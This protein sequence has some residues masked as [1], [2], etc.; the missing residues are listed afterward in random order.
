MSK[1]LRF[2]NRPTDIDCF[3]R[4]NP[5]DTRVVYKDAADSLYSRE[6]CYYEIMPKNSKNGI[7]GRENI[8]LPERSL[9]NK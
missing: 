6:T 1:N 5:Y 2:A 4:T 3:S 7:R 8:L 9:K